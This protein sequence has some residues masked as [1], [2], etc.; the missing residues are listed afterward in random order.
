MSPR[1]IEFEG[2]RYRLSGRYYRRQCWGASGPSSLHRAV[3]EF[4][5]GPIPPG[6]DVHHRDGDGT[7]NDIANL[8]CVPASEHQRAH[9]LQRVRDGSLRPPTAEAL[10]RAAEWHRSDD[11]REWHSRHGARTWDRREWHLRACDECG[12]EYRT[13]YPTR[14][15]FCHQNCKKAALRRRRGQPVGVR[16]DRRKTPLLSG[17][18]NPG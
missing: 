17:K 14:S 15:R 10:A 11:G 18:R 3:W 8:E 4:H 7:N 6:H 12:R 2:K 1:I 9:A 5:C 16:P 13:P